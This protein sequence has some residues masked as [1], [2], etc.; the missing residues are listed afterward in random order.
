[1]I[2]EVVTYRLTGTLG[3]GTTDLVQI[4]DTLDIANGR[5]DIRSVTVT[6]GSALSRSDARLWDANVSIT[7]ALGT[8][9][10]ND[11]VQIDFGTVVNDASG[12]GAD[13]QI[14]V[15]IQAVVVNTIENQE[16][17]VVTNTGQFRFQE[18]IN[19]DGTR[20]QQTLTDTVDVEIVEPTVEVTKT[21]PLGTTEADAGDIIGYQIIIENTSVIDAFDLTLQDILPAQMSIETGSF[22]A[23]LS[24]GSTDVQSYFTVTAGQVVHAGT[25]FDLAAG[26][27]ITI[28]YDAR[29]HA[30]VT[31]GQSL[32]NEVDI[33]WTSLNAEAADGSDADERGGDGDFD[34]PATGVDDYEDEDTAEITGELSPLYDFTKSVFSTS[35]SHTGTA[36]GTSATITD[37]VIGET[38][39]Y[40]LTAQLGRGTTPSVIIEDFLAL[41]NGILDI[42][43]VRIETGAAVTVTS[44]TPVITDSNLDTYD[45][46]V[47]IDFGS[48]VNDPTLSGGP[49]DE[50]IRI[51]I[52]AVVVNVL[53]NQ[54]GDVI[55]NLGRLTVLEDTDND[56]SADDEV[57]RES[58][59]DAEIV[60]PTITVAKA[61]TAQPINPDG[62]DTVSYEVVITNT[63]DIDAFDITFLDDLPG[64]VALEAGSF[65]AIRNS[66]AQD[67]SAFFTLNA[68]G[69]GSDSVTQSGTG[70]TLA[71]GD[72]ITV[73]YDVTI[74]ETIKD[75]DRQTNL[76][77]IEWTSTDGVNPDERGGD[78]D[79]D[80]PAGPT[81]PNNYE[82]E[83]ETTF[84]A[85][86]IGYDFDKSVFSTSQ[87]HTDDSA[88]DPDITDLTIG[89]TVTYALTAT[90]AEGTTPSVSIIDILNTTE[91]I[92][93]IE[94]ISISAGANLSSDQGPIES[95][96][97]TLEDVNLDG[98]FEKMTLVFGSI[99]NDASDS[100]DPA[101]DQLVV[102]VTA[103]VVNVVEN[104]DGDLICNEGT[105]TYQ[106][107][108]NDDGVIDGFDP[109][110][111]LTDCED[112]ELVE[113]N[114]TIDKSV[115]NPKPK[116][117]ETLTYTLTI[118]NDDATSTADGFDIDVLDRLP[119]G[120]TLDPSSVQLIHLGAPVNPTSIISNISDGL[121]LR[122]VLDRL[123]EGESIQITYEATVTSDISYYMAVLPN[124]ADLEWT[125]TP[126]NVID[127]RGGDGDPDTDADPNTTPDFY[128]DNDN[129]S[130][131]VHQPDLKIVKRDGGV[132]IL[133]GQ[134]V[135]YTME[136]TNQGRAT[137]LEVTVTDNISRYLAEGFQ[138]VSASDGG[139]LNG[140]GVVTWNLP[141]ME[142]DDVTTVRLTLRA[143]SVVPAG[144]EEIHNV[145]VADHL[146]IEPSPKD[147][148]DR[149]D[150][151]IRAFPD[152]V[153][154]KDD[155]LT[156]ATVGDTIT[157]TIT[158][159]NVGNQVASGVVIRDTLPPGVK[160]ISA[161]GGGR[162]SGNTV[163]WEIG[164]L[165]PGG[166]ETLRISVEVL[167]AGLK[168]NNVTIEDD[169]RGGPDPTPKNNR[170]SDETISKKGYQFDLNQNFL[171]GNG[172][173]NIA[174]GSFRAQLSGMYPQFE[175][176]HDSKIP[177]VLGTHMNSGLAQPGST[178]SLEVYNSRGEMIAE[179]SVV[180]DTGGNW[181]AT[182]STNQIDQQPARIVMRQTWS[183]P[184]VGDDTGYNFRTYFAPT[185]STA[186]YYSEE[187]SV[188]N[189][190]GKRAATEVLDLYE[191]SK[192]ILHL[193]W[194]G[195][196]Y[197][198]SARGALQSGS[199]N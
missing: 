97:P 155:G 69:A 25:G 188:W 192:C 179:Q 21:I 172:N 197:E 29:V 28:T 157:Y 177:I 59:V 147:N 113:P 124:E 176:I 108:S 12:T 110:V 52:D 168:V 61:I 140:A 181:L 128:D 185:F 83:D 38:I 94:S 109:T 18:D 66:D 5:L 36:F 153:V 34:T 169:G 160:F 32:L 132:Q 190:T 120:L 156:Y 111:N 161:S 8:D 64:K 76:V 67:V 182:F 173:Q 82:S 141:D 175:M 4:F 150:T 39:T 19:G 60:E 95:L 116:L 127:E 35:E 166:G 17:D 112:V 3:R 80:N 54:D 198:F 195:T 11:S 56:G 27:S 130:V 152:L 71:A 85:N 154:T 148:R 137:A 14:V 123:D 68:V 58:D 159:D 6:A 170:D 165:R 9:G 26:Q 133:P 136:V 187:L 88:Y 164:T 122:L 87:A 81:N 74:L 77:D 41:T 51:F 31:D 194:N 199:G 7:D 43:N 79:F 13:E 151:P 10:Y 103:R 100:L 158:Y 114:L 191:A 180:A 121:N 118:T 102:Y 178:I 48:V 84:I 107:D 174:G 63:S 146:D 47:R 196:T 55:N 117:A 162:L 22:V 50:Q 44:S 20:E 91:G 73:T 65:T 99:T 16:G 40:Q 115:N 189:V 171:F 119:V 125:S 23:T 2:G 106:E 30:T 135:T 33:E 72:F 142:V 129:E 105:F 75:G 96:V 70:F 78:G 183:T 144:L 89:E 104:R 37:L 86:L 186:S 126:G 145:G 46:Q 15:L 49:E 53:E 101:A 149:E 167:T 92:L 184:N 93:D 163:I 57:V 131:E 134:T 90:F 45:D 62:A 24:A 143:P 1:T 138:F 42:R 139:K 193:D 98:Y